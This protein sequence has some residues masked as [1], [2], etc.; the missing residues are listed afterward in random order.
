MFGIVDR[1]LIAIRYVY[2][3]KFILKYT[4]RTVKDKQKARKMNAQDECSF[5]ENI[6]GSFPMKLTLMKLHFV[7]T[8]TFV[9]GV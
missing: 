1:S 4:K 9:T 2:H 7:M 3:T 8:M 6:L 5:K